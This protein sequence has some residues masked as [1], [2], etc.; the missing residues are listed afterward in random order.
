VSRL[1]DG[2]QVRLGR[3]KIVRRLQECIKKLE[4]EVDVIGVLCTGEFPELKSQKL[5]ILYFF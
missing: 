5:L 1:R 3:E 2:T 4:K